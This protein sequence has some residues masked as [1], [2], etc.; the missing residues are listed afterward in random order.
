MI[1]FE[2]GMEKLPKNCRKCY[3]VDCSK[4]W[5]GNGAMDFSRPSSCSLRQLPTR[6]EAREIIENN[7]DEIPMDDLL[8]K[9]GFK[10][11]GK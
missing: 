2:T 9:L 5:S 3:M 10:E 4:K 8:D 7:V 1:V 11:V 6:E